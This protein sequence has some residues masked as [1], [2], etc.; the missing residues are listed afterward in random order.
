M[1]DELLDELRG[2]TWFTKLVL[3]SGY[4]QIRVA[5]E[6]VYKIAFRTHQGFYEFKVTPFGLTNAPASFPA[7]MNEVFQQQL[8][9]SV[10]VFFDDVLVYS[11][12][13]EAHL[14]HLEEVLQL[15]RQHKLFAKLSKCSFG[16][17]QMYYLGHVI[18]GEGVT[19]DPD[20]IQ[21][22]VDWPVPMTE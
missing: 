15:M 3:R 1:I 22:R 4:H 14:K 8:R 20:K 2:A 19:T 12:T 7:L 16:N 10:L 9:R 18:T 13:L 5:E 6:D 11:K 21:A 17:K